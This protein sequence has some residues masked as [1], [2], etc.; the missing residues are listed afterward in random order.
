LRT[1]FSEKR[2]LR[3]L[4]ETEEIYILH[5]RLIVEG[6]LPYLQSRTPK[7]LQEKLAYVFGNIKNIFEEAQIFYLSLKE[8]IESVD[9]V[10]HLFIESVNYLD[11]YSE[12]SRNKPTSDECFKEFYQ[13]IIK[14]TRKVCSTSLYTFYFIGDRK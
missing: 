9:K 12:Y 13:T 5:L 2:A 7:F 4:I 11:L 10:A 8:D 3:E 6:Y 1:N 14:V